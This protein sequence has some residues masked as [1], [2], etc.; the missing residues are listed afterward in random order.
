MLTL[1]KMGETGSESALTNCAPA[2]GKINNA[3]TSIS[4]D[5]VLFMS[6]FPH[7]MA[8]IVPSQNAKKRFFVK[9]L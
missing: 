3:K 6:I 8:S 4:A 5:A 1:D 7:R 9:K 2:T